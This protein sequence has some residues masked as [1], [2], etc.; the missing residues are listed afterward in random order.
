VTIAQYLINV[1]LMATGYIHFHYFILTSM[2]FPHSPL[3]II[4]LVGFEA[5]FGKPSARINQPD[6]MGCTSQVY[7]NGFAIASN[8]VAFTDSPICV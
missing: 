3:S 1:L 8:Q 7:S 4:A 6:R 2:F 5:A